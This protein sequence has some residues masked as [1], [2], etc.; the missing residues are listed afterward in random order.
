M[1]RVA[2]IL[3]LLI[4]LPVPAIAASWDAR[5]LLT[6][7]VREHA[8]WADVRVSDVR[9]GSPAPAAPPDRILHEGPSPLGKSVFVLEFANGKRIAASADVRAFDR[10]VISSRNL[11]KGSLLSDDDLYEALVDV[12][13]IP[14][15]ALRAP[16]QA[17][18]KPLARS[19]L[20]NT[21]LTEAMIA[22]SA[23]VR[24]GTRVALVLETPGLVIRSA[25]RLRQNGSVGEQVKVQSLSSD[26]VITGLLVDES[27]VKVEF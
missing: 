1:R 24:T 9:L 17:V 3:T 14:R 10:V 13:K 21:P 11:R 2:A 15:S 5:E 12:T 4:T 16:D 22:S 27:T 19:V 8:P 7:F 18:G 20:A 23:R 26:R 6:A 25:G